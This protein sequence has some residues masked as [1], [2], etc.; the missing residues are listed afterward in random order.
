ML[1][2]Q[3]ESMRALLQELEQQTRKQQEALQT[4]AHAP[5]EATLDILRMPLAAYQKA[6]GMAQ[7]LTRQGLEQVQ[8]ATQQARERHSE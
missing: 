1:K 8:Q 5:V 4:L 7:N 3:A 6:L 2:S